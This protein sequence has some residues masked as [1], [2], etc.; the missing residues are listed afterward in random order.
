MPTFL[1]HASQ[2]HS[3]VHR[4][5]SHTTGASQTSLENLTLCFDRR[6]SQ[7]GG[8][9]F[10]RGGRGWSNP[11]ALRRENA[12]VKDDVK[13]AKQLQKEADRRERSKKHLQAKAAV[14]KKRKGK[15]SKR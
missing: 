6:H 9:R 2:R 7:H 15:K 4:H 10:K 8:Y 11:L 14:K 1:F 3:S 12:N 13:S 5:L